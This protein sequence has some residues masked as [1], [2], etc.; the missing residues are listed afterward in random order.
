MTS[1]LTPPKLKA[2]YAPKGRAGEYAGL[3]LNLYRGCDHG[4]DY[5]YSPRVLHMTRDAFATPLPRKNILEMTRTDAKALQDAGNT[6]SILLCFTTDPYCHADVRLKLT[7]QVVSILLKHEQPL[8]IL[9]KGGARSQRDFDIMQ[10]HPDLVTYATTL[11]FD[12]LHEGM[13]TLHEPNA[14]PTCERLAAL[15]KAKDLGFGTWVSCEPVIDPAQTIALIR[16]AA[17]VT[18]LFKVGKWN[19]AR[20]AAAT[21]WVQF[22]RDVQ[23]TCKDVGAQ[24][25]LKN[26][27]AP[28]LLEANHA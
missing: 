11:T 27:L 7:R 4:C 3:A 20:E 12:P 23:E 16:E 25:Y 18:D 8:T 1:P 14:A 15:T 17:P 5:C 9:T 13:R 6:T 21:N 19:Y 24:Y 28:Y 22:V 2:V 10:A 26:D